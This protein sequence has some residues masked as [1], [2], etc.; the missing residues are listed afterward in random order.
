M[1]MPA[2]DGWIRDVG[3]AAAEPPRA[4]AHLGATRAVWSSMREFPSRVRG[5]LECVEVAP[6]PRARSRSRPRRRSVERLG[7]AP[8][9]ADQRAALD[10]AC[11]P[12][13]PRQ[14]REDL[15]DRRV[16]RRGEQDPLVLREQLLDDVRQR[17]RLAGPRWSPDER[18]V[19][20][21][22]QLHGGELA[23]IET[24]V[25]AAQRGGCTR[26]RLLA[27]Q[28]QREGDRMA[29]DVEVREGLQQAIV[30]EPRG[31]DEHDRRRGHVDRLGRDQREPCVLAALD[32]RALLAA[33]RSQRAHGAGRELVARGP[34]LEPI[35]QRAEIVAARQRDPER[36]RGCLHRR[37]LALDTAL[38][39]R[40]EARE[41]VL[42]RPAT[43]A[44]SA[45]R[46]H[47]PI[48]ARGFVSGRTAQRPGAQPVRSACPRERSRS[49]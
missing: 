23:R 37:E 6:A 36:L 2:E 39:G 46:H 30:E 22:A 28:P 11:E 26:M 48:S 33:Q 19:A 44:R 7:G 41:Q 32:D 9:E 42:H 29:V 13:P 47:P 38:K 40:D 20:V 27:E 1:V 10:R 45:R 14:L 25:I 4:P 18:E 12:R 15:V 49:A 35:A 43:V 24:R 21:A 8:P 31:D 34:E 17:D 3:A 5:S 16:R